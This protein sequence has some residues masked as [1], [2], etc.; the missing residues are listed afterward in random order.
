MLFSLKYYEINMCYL[1]ELNLSFFFQ[2]KIVLNFNYVRLS[3]RAD[4]LERK[5]RASLSGHFIVFLEI[6]S[7]LCIIYA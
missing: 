7:Y 4:P 6:G 1:Y 2:N 5:E 3:D